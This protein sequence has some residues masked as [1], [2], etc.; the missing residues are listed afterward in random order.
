[1]NQTGRDAYASYGIIPSGAKDVSFDKHIQSNGKVPV[2]VREEVFDSDESIVQILGHEVFEIEELRYVAKAPIS[3][4]QYINL[5][6][7][8][9]FDNLHYNAVLEGDDLLRA[10]RKLEGH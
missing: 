1:V 7:D 5:V 8:G 4:K 10:Y 6:G 9:I 2:Y 3:I